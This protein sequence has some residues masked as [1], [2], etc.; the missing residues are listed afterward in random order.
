MN[1]SFCKLSSH[2]KFTLSNCANSVNMLLRF[3]DFSFL[4]FTIVTVEM[5]FWITFINVL[6]TIFYC[7]FLHGYYLY[8][9]IR[10]CLDDFI[11]LAGFRF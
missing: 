1:T 5:T 4:I 6:M 2:V 10:Y 9:S 8:I 7:D 11:D 3:Y